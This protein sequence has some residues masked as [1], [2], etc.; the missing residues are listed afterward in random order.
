MHFNIY[1]YKCILYRYIMLISEFLYILICSLSSRLFPVNL[2]ASVSGGIS[3]MFIRYTVRFIVLGLY[4]EQT[5]GNG[6]YPM[7]SHS[8]HWRPKHITSHT[9]HITTM[10]TKPQWDWHIVYTYNIT[11]LLSY[12]CVVNHVL[13]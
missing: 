12:E 4:V 3:S 5:P 8:N 13:N 11:Y 2:M 1:I 7:H 10:I 9:W 6:Y